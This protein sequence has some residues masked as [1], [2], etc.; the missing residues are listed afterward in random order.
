M[1]RKGPVAAIIFFLLLPAIQSCGHPDRDKA[2]SVQYKISGTASGARITITLPGGGMEQHAV[3]VPY[4][5]P[6]YG[7]RLNQPAYV[8]AQNAGP[9]GEVVVEILL[10]GKPIR[11]AKSSGP[12]AI[13]SASWLAGS[14]D[15]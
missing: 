12:Y 4:S 9:D 14:K 6:A 10:D 1:L 3:K 5:T 8:S 2:F 13:A 15:R 7:F 11:R